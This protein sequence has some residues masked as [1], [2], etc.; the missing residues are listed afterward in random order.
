MYLKNMT[1]HF[2]LFI[3]WGSLEYWSPIYDLNSVKSGEEKGSQIKLKLVKLV[4]K[5]WFIGGW[6]I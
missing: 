5:E 3:D 2:C 6:Y 4:V 1:N